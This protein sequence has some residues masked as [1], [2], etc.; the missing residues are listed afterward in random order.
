MK[1]KFYF[2]VQVR[3]PH[4]RNVAIKSLLAAEAMKRDAY[5][6]D[7]LNIP[8]P[9]GHQSLGVVSNALSDL[10]ISG[11]SNVSCKSLYIFFLF[12][13]LDSIFIFCEGSHSCHK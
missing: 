2:N 13:F 1:Q 4:R 9:D 3:C 5:K 7:S 10:S 11:Q 8:E 12:K 6:P